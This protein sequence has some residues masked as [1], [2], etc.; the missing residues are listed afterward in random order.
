[1]A[2]PS[3]QLWGGLRQIKLPFTVGALVE[4]QA[5]VQGNTRLVLYAAKRWLVSKKDFQELASLADVGH[6]RPQPPDLGPRFFQFRH[7]KKH[8]GGGVMGPESVGLFHNGLG[9]INPLVNPLGRT[10][11]GGQIAVVSRLITLR[12]VHPQPPDFR[13]ERKDGLVRR[14]RHPS[15]GAHVVM[16]GLGPSFLNVPKLFVCHMTSIITS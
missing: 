8:H 1:M 6:H 7:H 12:R 13:D 5:P 15:V 2:V 3:G 10:V 14:D 16:A 4:R 9:V 11:L